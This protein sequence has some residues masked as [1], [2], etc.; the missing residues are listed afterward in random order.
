MFDRF[1]VGEWAAMDA[2]EDLSAEAEVDDMAEIYY[3]SVWS[4][5]QYEGRRTRFRG[6]RTAV[7]CS[8]TNP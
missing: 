6:I 1:I 5:T 4:E 8:I 7:R 2:L 3:P